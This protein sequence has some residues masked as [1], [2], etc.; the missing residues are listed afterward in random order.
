MR[1]P[2]AQIRSIVIQSCALRGERRGGLPFT[3]TAGVEHQRRESQGQR[4]PYGWA[5]P[6]P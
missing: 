4:E 3:R 5:V 6:Q 1:S 2:F